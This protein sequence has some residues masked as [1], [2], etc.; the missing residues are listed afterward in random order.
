MPRSKATP[1]IAVI[2]ARWASDFQKDAG[3]ASLRNLLKAWQEF[4]MEKNKANKIEIRF[5]EPKD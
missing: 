5:I 3:E 1:Q 4:C 2:S